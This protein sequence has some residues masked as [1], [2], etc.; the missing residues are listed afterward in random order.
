MNQSPE[1]LFDRIRPIIALF[2]DVWG[3]SVPVAYGLCYDSV[4]MMGKKPEMTLGVSQKRH[5]TSTSHKILNQPLT[6]A[7]LSQLQSQ[8]LAVGFFG[9]AELDHWHAKHAK[10]P[11]KDTL[12]LVGLVLL[13]ASAYPSLRLQIG[14][15]A[16][17]PPKKT[18]P[19]MGIKPNQEQKP[20]LFVAVFLVGLGAMIWL[21]LP[22]PPPPSD[23]A[24]HLPKNQKIPD[25][26][27]VR[28]DDKD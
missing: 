9:K 7:T 24:K 10:H 12:C 3:V 18:N 2:A 26:A 4:V 11:A 8:A 27:I 1:Q 16:I 22:K 20:W 13:W 6:L 5:L 23:P 15:P 17:F 14:T 28:I 19:L 21:S 25:V